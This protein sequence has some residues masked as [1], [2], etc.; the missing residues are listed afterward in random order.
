MDTHRHR[1]TC[2]LA[3][4]TGFLMIAQSATGMIFAELYRDGEFALQAWRI[5]DPVTLLLAVPVLFISLVLTLRGS[6]RGYLVLLGTM[7]YAFYNY[8]FYLFGA[9]LNVHFLLYAVL[10]VTS[11]IAF[12]TGVLAITPDEVSRFFSNRTPVRTVSVYMVVWALI[13]GIAWSVQALVFA[14]TGAAPEIGEEPFRLI[15]AL[16]LTLVVTPV[17]LGAHWLW[18]RHAWG[19][20]VAV[21]LNVKGV[22]YAGL[23]SIGS[24]TGGGDPLLGL[25][26]FFT[27][28]S[29][30]SLVAL[31]AGMK[32]R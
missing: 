1:L 12:I 3:A 5:N 29:L 4:L 28:G 30:A 16:D 25:W 15:A 11:A 9:A 14:V 24:I 20:V 8:A 23:L 10:V 7:Q 18:K 17:A 32:A 31:L 22:I 19:F 26:I 6:L 21:V 2:I 13:L 27:V